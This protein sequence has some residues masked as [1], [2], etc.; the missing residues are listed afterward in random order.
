[1]KQIDVTIRTTEINTY[2]VEVDDD[3]DVESAWELEGIE[4]WPQV[5]SDVKDWSVIGAEE[6]KTS[7]PNPRN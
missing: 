2:R 6:V 3:F 4:E 7:A 5:D 1:M